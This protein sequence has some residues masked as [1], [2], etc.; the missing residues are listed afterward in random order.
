SRRRPA[1]SPSRHGWSSWCW[2]GR[3]SATLA[4][5]ADASPSLRVGACG[6][7]R[8]SVGSATNPG[9][10][11]ARMRSMRWRLVTTVSLVLAGAVA[12]AQQEG[13]TSPAPLPLITSQDLLDGLKNSGRWLTYSGD[14]TGRRHSPLTQITPQ[15]AARMAAQWTFQAEGMPI[16][17]G[18]EG[19]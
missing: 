18:F 15:N 19:T 5:P 12:A 10:R 4:G 14:Y 17:R 6:R 7:A 2:P 9:E 16:G 11:R 1:P 8:M 3:R 13:S